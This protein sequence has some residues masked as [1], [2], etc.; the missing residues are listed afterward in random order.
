MDLK[1]LAFFLYLAITNASKTKGLL[2]DIIVS[3]DLK[4]KFKLKH[5]QQV[6]N[7]GVISNEI[8]VLDGFDLKIKKGEFLVLVGPSGSVKSVFLD[9][10]GGLSAPTSGIVY[11]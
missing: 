2:M 4:K 11:L 7:N 1:S 10:V 5:G 3:K 6:N 9:I 8:E